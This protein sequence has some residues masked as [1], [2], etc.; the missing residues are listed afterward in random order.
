M[1]PFKQNKDNT[2]AISQYNDNQTISSLISQY[3]YHKYI[4]LPSMR[5]NA[6]TIIC[7]LIC[8]QLYKDS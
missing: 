2:S 4:A 6:A 7:S 1:Q 8:A 3:W 5:T